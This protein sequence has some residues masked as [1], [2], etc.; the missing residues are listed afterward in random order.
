MQLTII[1][2]NILHNFGLDRLG[3]DVAQV[4]MSTPNFTF[5]EKQL[6]GILIVLKLRDQ[7]MTMLIF[8]S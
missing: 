5:R 6:L 1:S 8:K 3:R 4:G 2:G 7:M